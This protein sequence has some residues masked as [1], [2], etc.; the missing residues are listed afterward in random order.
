M[1][2]LADI[3]KRD[4]GISFSNKQVL[5]LFLRMDFVERMV[6]GW[7]VQGRKLY[8]IHVHFEFGGNWT[9]RRHGRYQFLL[10]NMYVP[11]IFIHGGV[12]QM[13]N[14]WQRFLANKVT[15][16]PKIGVGQLRD[17]F[18]TEYG[19]QASYKSTWHG[20]EIVL[21]HMGGGDAKSFQSIPIVCAR[22]KAMDPNGHVDWEPQPDNRAFRSMFV[23]PSASGRS[24]PYMRPHVGLDACH[25]KNQRYPS[26]I[27]LATCLDGNNNISIIAY[28]IV[29]RENEE[30]L[31]NVKQ[32][33]G[34][35]MEK[36]FKVLH[37]CKTEERSLEPE[38]HQMPVELLLVGPIAQQRTPRLCSICKQPGH[39]RR[40]CGRQQSSNRHPSQHSTLTGVESQGVEV[41][42]TT[43]D[44]NGEENISMTDDDLDFE[45]IHDEELD[46]VPIEFLW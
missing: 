13:P 38:E 15:S 19:R 11:V 3:I 21:S 24:F 39:D 35:E 37:R 7:S 45:G 25:S 28:A 23:C 33:F 30:N 10:P 44:D 14:G 41:N 12:Q 43:D 9:R 34:T 40:T 5:V 1:D 22:L 2:I 16:N 20:R 36:F 17:T 31:R 29:D 27:M 32:R 18:R 26:F 6:D 46:D 42:H 8:R 4:L